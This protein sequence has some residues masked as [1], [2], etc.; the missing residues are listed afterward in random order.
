MEFIVSVETKLGNRSLGVTEVMRVYRDEHD[1]QPEDVGL[2]LDEGKAVIQEVQHQIV[3]DQIIL[4]SA[5]AKV[6]EH[7]GREK[8]DKDLRSRV[9]RTVFGRVDVN[10]YRYFKCSCLKFRGKYDWPLYWLKKDG[11]TP[12][13]RYLITRWGS[14]VPYRQAATIL[15][16]FL[17]LSG[18]GLSHATVRRHTMAVGVLIDSRATEPDEYEFSVK[19]KDFDPPP[20]GRLLV[21]IDGTYVKANRRGF[22]RQHF[23]LA[24]RVERNGR[25]D[26]RFA[27]V[28]PNPEAAL[29]LMKTA[30]KDHGLTT[31]SSVAVL[32]DGADG[33][34]NL[35]GNSVEQGARSVL[36][37][38][39]ISMRLRPM[40]QMLNTVSG[41]IADLKDSAIFSKLLPNLRHQMWHG[42]WNEANVRMREIFDCCEHDPAS[43]TPAKSA[44]LARFRKHVLDLR[45]YLRNNWN[46]L[47]NYSDAR[48]KGLRI[49]SAPAESNMH[50]IVNQRMCKLQ[51]MRWTAEDAHNLLQVRCAVLDGRLS[52][53]FG[54]WYPRFQMATEINEEH[55][56]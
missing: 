39:H 19:A 51:P 37:W 49:S 23:V 21:A 22:E 28:A 38:F 48:R 25:L 24:G 47:T 40:E 50:H 15:R 18:D 33:L 3:T 8:N 45:D 36:D 11:A 55:Y 6:C 52:R 13:Y 43:T 56:M 29:M 14:L 17:P 10:C 9:I 27:W 41:S 12:E 35:V 1:V 34:K 5:M 16:E 32:A 46:S 31:D 53:L 54:Q 42:Q 7:C 20:A 44:R 4:V 30:L 26:G 2:S